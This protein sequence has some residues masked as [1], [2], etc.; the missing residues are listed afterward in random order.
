MRGRFSLGVA[1]IHFNNQISTDKLV[2]IARLYHESQSKLKAVGH[3]I[4]MR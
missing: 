1:T 3:D 2:F 4:V